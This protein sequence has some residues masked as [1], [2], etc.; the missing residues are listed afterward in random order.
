MYHA[1][2]NILDFSIVSQKGSTA[3]FVSRGAAYECIM[4]TKL[5]LSPYWRGLSPGSTGR[6][7]SPP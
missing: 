6:G 2:H 7:S 4:I 5:E 1:G 3:K